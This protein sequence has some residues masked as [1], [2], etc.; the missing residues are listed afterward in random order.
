M[1]RRVVVTGASGNVGTSVLR[2][3]SADPSVGSIVG[4][5]RRRP[6]WT[7]DKLVWET[8]DVAGDD[9]V[10][11]FAGADT[12]VHLAWM[13]QPARDPATTW[14]TNVLGSIRVFDAA[15]LAGV[16]SLV[17][18]SSVGAYSP[19]PKDRKVT[20]DWPTH[21]WPAAS[22]TR[23]KSY[24]ERVLDTYERD[25]P[26]IRVVRMRPAFLFKRESASEQ[27]RLFAG[28]LVR[29][30][31]VR[32][33]PVVPD[34]PGLKL[35]ALH[36]ADAARAYRLA[37]LGDI[38][39]PVNLAADPVLDAHMLAELL[40]ARV[41]KLPAWAVRAPLAAAWRL[42]ATPATPDLF[43][44]ALRLPLLDTTRARTE[45]GWQPEHGAADAVAELLGG[46]RNG[47]GMA[48]PPLTPDRA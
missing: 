47:A 14:R 33:V 37:V 28:P 36:T 12:V 35:Q 31:L 30:N 48:T 25:H 42:H 2:E 32:F 19:G 38:R 27:R 41:V 39:G 15:A 10:P 24:V 45:L 22:Y 8:A 3:L 34:L 43:D 23:E 7:C 29:G 44:A 5:A 9:L 4:V 16:S 6:E 11:L 17:Y 1:S 13:I 18:A 40:G 26:H 20:E 21:G 46:L